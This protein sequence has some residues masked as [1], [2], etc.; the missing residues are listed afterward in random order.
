MAY[1][2][3]GTTVANIQVLKVASFTP[4]FVNHP[5]HLALGTTVFCSLFWAMDLLTEIVGA[6]KALSVLWLSFVCTALVALWM[7][8]AIAM[9]PAH[10]PENLTTHTA[11]QR[12]FRP[13]PIL[14]CSS[15][16]AYLASQTLDIVV[17]AHLKAHTGGR[18]LGLRSLIS[19]ILATF[20][21]H[22]LFSWLAFRLLPA[23]PIPFGLWLDAYLL[24][25]YGLR[26]FLAAF[27]PV[28]VYS[29]VRL[30][31]RFLGPARTS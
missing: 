3:I 5:I 31:R 6:R 27:S 2:I 23:V 24:N 15:I 29:G 18:Y 20:L 19:S 9:P 25:G 28:V 13:T 26:L 17:F 22:L 11:M 16:L 8:L 1:V 12:L 30:H 14:L 4:F 21:D 10:F 7:N